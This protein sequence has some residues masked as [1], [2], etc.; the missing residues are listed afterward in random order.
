M[1]SSLDILSALFQL[2]NVPEVTDNISG[3]VYIGEPLASS[4]KEDIA[5][6]LLNNPN[7]YLQSGYGN[8]NIYAYQESAGRANL[9]RFN[10]ITKIVMPMLKDAQ[11]GD[12]FVQVNDDKGVFKDPDRDGMYYYNIKITFQTI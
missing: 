11:I 5:L 10:E 7:S 6:N 1:K 2:L 12:F 3:K 4:Q 8:V 9:K